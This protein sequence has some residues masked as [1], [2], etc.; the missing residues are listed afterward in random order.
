VQELGAIAQN[1]DTLEP[2]GKSTRVKSF[3]IGIDVSDFQEV[4]V[5]SRSNR[6]VSQ[7]IAGLGSRK[8]IIGVDRL[9]YS[10][11]IPQ[12]MEAYERF[13]VNNTGQRGRVTYLQIAPTSRSEVPEYE[14]VSRAVN[15]TA[16][17]DKRLGGRARL[18][19]DPVRH[20]HV[21]PGCARRRVPTCARC[22]CHTDA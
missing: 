15:E 19:A 6:I 11:G 18:G 7:T 2:G 3:P 22:T 21:S 16:G 20:Q 4:A 13:L 17:E 5:R 8:L 14:M 10:K 9:D 12:R 1:E